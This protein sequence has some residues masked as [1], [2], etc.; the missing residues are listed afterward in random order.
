MIVNRDNDVL[1]VG[2]KAMDRLVNGTP[3]NPIRTHVENLTFGAFAMVE[4]DG[5]K[6]ALEG[7][8]ISWERGKQL[9]GVLVHFGLTDIVGD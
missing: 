3:D 1:L 6:R 7:F 5:F 8:R 9:D 4:L 2:A